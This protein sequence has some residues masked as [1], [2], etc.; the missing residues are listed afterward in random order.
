MTAS[1]WRLY[2]AVIART[3]PMA[4]LVEWDNDVPDWSVLREEVQSAQAM[5]HR[6]A[7]QAA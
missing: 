4:T 2:E 6:V 7:L 5:L 1:V 3:G